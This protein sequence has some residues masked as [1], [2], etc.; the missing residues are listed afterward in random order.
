MWSVDG[1]AT[2]IFDNRK[3]SKVPRRL[4]KSFPEGGENHGP[5]CAIGIGSHPPYGDGGGMKQRPFPGASQ[6]TAEHAG[7][8]TADVKPSD[9]IL[10]VE[11]VGGEN[12]ELRLDFNWTL[13]FVLPPAVLTPQR[14]PQI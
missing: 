4:N 9:H 10:G 14:Y 6:T 5:K 7:V 2:Q 3:R 12:S 1:G 11:R 13:I 8:R